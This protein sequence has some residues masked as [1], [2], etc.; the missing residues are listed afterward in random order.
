M[1]ETVVHFTHEA[2]F[3]VGGIGAVLDGLLGSSAYVEAVPR[4]VVVGPF[5]RY[6]GD[7]M[8]RMLAP[9]NKLTVLYSP[10]LGVDLVDPEVAERLRGVETDYGVALL[11]GRRVFGAAEHEVLLVDATFAAPERIHDFK[12]FVW[13]RYGLDSGR[14]DQFHEFNLYM[15]MAQATF[16]AVRSL[17]GDQQ[18]ER[19]IVAHE[20]MGLPLV[21]AAQLNEPQAWKTIFYAHEMATARNLVEEHGG[22]DTRFYNA[23]F[24]AQREGRSLEEVFGEQSHFYK[25]PLIR[26]AIHCTNIFAV[27]D[28]VVSELRFLGGTFAW[29]NIDLVYNGVVPMTVNL[30]DKYAS[31][32]KLQQYTAN[33]MGYWPDYVFTHVARLV[34]SKGMWRDLRVIEH[35]DHMLASEGKRAV[36]FVVATAVPTGKRPEDVRHW[37]YQYGWPVGHR[38]DNGDLVGQEVSFFFDGIDR[39]NQGSQAVKAVLVNQFG[40]NQERCGYRMPAD[41]EF[42]DLRRGSDLEFGQS[43]YEP[44]GIAQVEPLGAGAVTV[45]SNVCGCVGFMERAAAG[46][47]LPNLVVADYVG[48]PPSY[49]IWSAHDALRIDQGMRDYIERTNSYGV[50]LRIFKRLP[51]NDVETERLLAR[52]QEIAA[53]MSWDV[54]V[55]DYLLP[56]LD[57]P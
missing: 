34:V 39:F 7:E 37:E 24:A 25:H 29:K 46:S 33:L 21:F 41:M 3:K 13:Q 45:M 49:N 44:F 12:F 11:Y 4:T 18:G 40:W 26:Q 20:W 47:E 50:A 9:R 2:G 10:L 48:V 51:T 28:L 14:Y 27:G 15:K 5:N 16:A 19:I 42:I 52:G 8:D 38:G 35:L 36:L 55:R 54:V 53:R 31:K 6:N 17:L 32:R 43:V 23:L 56:G 30:E 57:R 22:H 1:L